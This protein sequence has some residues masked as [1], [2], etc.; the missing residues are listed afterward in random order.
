M[1]LES[2]TVKLLLRDFADEGLYRQ[3]AVIEEAIFEILTQH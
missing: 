3:K 1:T 2:S